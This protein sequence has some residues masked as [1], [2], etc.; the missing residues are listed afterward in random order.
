LTVRRHFRDE[1]IVLCVRWYL[2]YPLSYREQNHR[3]VKKR[4]V[5]SEW[6]RSVD[7]ALNT[8]AGYEALNMIRKGRIRWLP[9]TDITLVR[10]GSLNA[11]LA[12]LHNR[13]CRAVPELYRC[14][15]AV[16]DTTWFVASLLGIV[17]C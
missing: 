6:F 2:R 4:V 11:S 17:A 1:I 5:A 16:C 3:Y 7:G 15:P 12:S 8:F 13:D 10:S 9:K 14:T